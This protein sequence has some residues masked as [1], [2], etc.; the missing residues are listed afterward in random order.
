MPRP[1]YRR[2]INLASPA[3]FDE[4]VAI[5]RAAGPPTALPGHYEIQVPVPA[6]AIDKW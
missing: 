6:G 5:A 1:L 4:V 2:L 3:V